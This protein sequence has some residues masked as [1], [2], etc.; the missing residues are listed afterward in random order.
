M[1]VAEFNP[2]TTPDDERVLRS[3]EDWGVG[4]AGL[5]AI[6]TPLTAATDGT[7]KLVRRGAAEQLFDLRSDPLEA[8][9][10]DAGDHR[11]AHLRAALDPQPVEAVEA[12]PEASAE[13]L[14]EIEE[15]M[16]LLG[17]M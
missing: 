1:A 8:H 2:P 16:R 3:V 17:Y 11:A 13:E 9:P 14:A 5:R 4:E 12:Q 6:T 7:F 15:R 10:L